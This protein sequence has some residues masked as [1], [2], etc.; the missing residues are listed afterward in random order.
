MLHIPEQVSPQ[1]VRD[2]LSCPRFATSRPSRRFV[3]TPT[4]M[5][6]E[7]PNEIPA[8]NELARYA[9]QER[10]RERFQR[11]YV[12]SNT[13]GPIN[14]PRANIPP[15]TTP[16]STYPSGTYLPRT[17]LEDSYQQKYD[18]NGQAPNISY[19]PYQM[20]FLQLEGSDSD[21]MC[22]ATSNPRV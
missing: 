13:P 10:E 6:P 19:T 3:S 7:P 22:F 21:I 9:P 4:S 11:S 12:P 14:T 17:N 20:T 18:D 16:G 2:G 5:D 15:S 8:P 1:C